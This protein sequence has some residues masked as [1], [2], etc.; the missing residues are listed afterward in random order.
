MA[1]KIIIPEHS[2]DKVVFVGG[3]IGSTGEHTDVG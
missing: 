2:E 1:W 3:A